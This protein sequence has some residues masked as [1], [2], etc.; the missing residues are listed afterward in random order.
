[1]IGHRILPV[2]GLCP[3]YRHIKLR[4]E[5]YQPLCLPSLFV[6]IVTKDYVPESFS[7]FADA[8]ANPMK[9][10]SEK[11][12]RAKQLESLMDD[13]EEETAGETD[14]FPASASS[15]LMLPPTPAELAYKRGSVVS[16]SG[17]L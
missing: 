5:C 11:E 14:S 15:E 4:N 7:D 17:I 10:L 16:L 12:K 13:D 2:D 9:Y 6:D 3:G 1:M 8:L